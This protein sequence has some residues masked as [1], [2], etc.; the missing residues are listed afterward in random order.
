[1]AIGKASD[2]KVYD[3]FFQSRVA[4]LLSQNGELFGAATRGAIVLTTESKRGNYAY[5]AFFKNITGLVTRR[6]NTSTASVTDLAMTQDEIIEVKLSRKIGPVAQTR[7]AFLK[8]IGTYDEA[9]FTGIMAQFAA[10]A[11]SLE[12]VNTALGALAQALKNQSASYS[13]TSSLGTMETD[14]LVGSLAQMGDQA[15][16]IVAWVMHSKPYYDLVREQIVANITGVASFNVANGTP[17]SL[18]RPIIVTDSTALIANLNSPDVN[19]YFTLGLTE[20]AAS[21]INTEEEVIVIDQ[22]TGLDTLV[23]R[24]QGE[25]AYNLALKGFKWDV[26]N[27][28][29]NPTSS[30]VF[31]GSNW[32]PAYT[33]VKERAGTVIATL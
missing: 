17:L 20:G 8:A 19:N 18:N 28:G 15:G 33:D 11:M 31:T 23:V 1:M 24:Y 4:E 29:A 12:M 25:Y 22:V 32:D 16:R 2:F 21:V 6:D 26:Q 7:D 27:G 5:T 3:E 10:N 9:T 30:A 13:G 14:L